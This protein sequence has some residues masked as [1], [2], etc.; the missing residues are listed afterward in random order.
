MASAAPR[1]PRPAPGAESTRSHH[2]R[3]TSSAMNKRSHHSRGRV[4]AL[5]ATSS[6]MNAKPGDKW[7]RSNNVAGC[8]G[9]NIDDTTEDESSTHVKYK[10]FTKRKSGKHTEGSITM[11]LLTHEQR[12][13]ALEDDRSRLCNEIGRGSLL[14]KTVTDKARQLRQ[15]HDAEMV[16]KHREELLECQTAMQHRY[17][18]HMQMKIVEI[19][20]QGLASDEVPKFIG[21]THLRQGKL[22]AEN[23]DM[24]HARHAVDGLVRHASRL[25]GM[26][27][28]DRHMLM[29]AALRIVETCL[30]DGSE[31][32]EHALAAARLTYRSSSASTWAL[33]VFQTALAL[34]GHGAVGDASHV[35]R[36]IAPDDSVRKSAWG[37]QCRLINVFF[38]SS[39]HSAT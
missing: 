32:P 24:R 36:T 6:A 10:L 25:L 19:A 5:A 21:C 3:K 17:E 35:V 22:G 26:G 30:A 31:L 33:A 8:A 12:Q 34:G 23:I 15:G 9:K 1:Q 7:N 18:E 29:G 28:A 14:V 13:F 4:A 11:S 38:G 37:I 20:Q 39:M 2:S 16:A 27:A